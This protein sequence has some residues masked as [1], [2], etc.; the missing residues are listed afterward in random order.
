[1]I[2]MTAL[3]TVT[4]IRGDAV[5]VMA[6]LWTATVIERLKYLRRVDD[7]D[8]DATQVTATVTAGGD[9]DG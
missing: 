3:K 2:L 6:D 8:G 1:M 9:G 5:M 4:A 7:G